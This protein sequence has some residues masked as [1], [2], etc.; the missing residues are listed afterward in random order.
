MIAGVEISPYYDMLSFTD[1]QSF[2][3]TI[4]NLDNQIENWNDSFDIKY[5]NLNDD[6]LDSLEDA[7]P[8]HEEQPLI[9]FENNFDGYTSLRNDISSKED[10][11]LVAGGTDLQNDPDTSFIVDPILQS[12]LNQ[13][14]E[15]KI[16]DTIYIIKSDGWVGVYN[17]DI[18]MV[19][20][21]E[22]GI[23][24]LD[25]PSQVD[26]T[27]LQLYSVHFWPFPASG[28]PNPI[29]SGCLV[30]RNASSEGYAFNSSNDR[31]I[32]W[33]IAIRNYPWGDYVIGKTKGF[34]KKNNGSWK[35]YRSSLY[36][37]VDGQFT[38]DVSNC[39][40]ANFNQSKSKNRREITKKISRWPY[41][42][43]AVKNEVLGTHTGAGGVYKSS[44]LTW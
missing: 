32:K 14:N 28:W 17:S 16:G 22:N 30:K 40:K 23:I 15:V 10:T 24:N 25:N 41:E 27:K 26:T 38:T 31:R 43:L 34:K 37:Q 1:M 7:L 44:I 20:D 2:Q 13:K 3:K 6:A 18:K 35:K 9:N 19:R 5:P 8:F 4:E 11:W 12:V 33:K 39:H 42:A 36:V 29:N 21:I